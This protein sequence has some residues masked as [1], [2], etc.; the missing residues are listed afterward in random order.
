MQG[1]EAL[2]A[3]QKQDCNAVES[4][5]SMK[6]SGIENTSTSSCTYMDICEGTSKDK[7]FDKASPS[8]DRARARTRTSSSGSQCNQIEKGN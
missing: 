6:G 2:L 7:E 5:V 1:F 8:Y 4:I 3:I